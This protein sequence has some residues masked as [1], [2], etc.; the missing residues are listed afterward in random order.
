VLY[1]KVVCWEPDRI[2]TLQ[3]PIVSL[4]YIPELG[5][6]GKDLRA[7]HTSELG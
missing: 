4:C 3:L 7:G 1:N 5:N 6:V 2:L